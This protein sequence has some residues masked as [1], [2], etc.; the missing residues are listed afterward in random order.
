MAGKRRKI[1]KPS[2]RN[3]VI[4]RRRMLAAEVAPNPLNWRQH[5][6]KQRKALEA[7]LREVGQVGEIYA[8]HSAR[9]GGKL[10]LLDGHLRAE[11]DPAQEWDV[12]ITDLTDEEADRILLSRD[13]IAA[14]ATAGREALEVLLRNVQTG[15]EALAGLAADLAVEHGILPE[16]SKDKQD[17][18]AEAEFVPER[19]G[20]VVMVDSEARQVELLERLTGE[21]YQC[22]SLIG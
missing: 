15:E 17:A 4:E 19:W 18:G 8:Y 13:P 7:V 12:A 2:L 10:T 5:P 11:L 1:D 9:N 6:E 14:M 21:G 3:R 20:V 16:E 22:R